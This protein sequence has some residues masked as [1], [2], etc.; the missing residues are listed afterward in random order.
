MLAQTPCYAH[1]PFLFMGNLFSSFSWCHGNISTFLPEQRSD[2]L[3]LRYLIIAVGTKVN[4]I[5]DILIL[6]WQ[7]HETPGFCACCSFTTPGWTV[8][9]SLHCCW[10]GSFSLIVRILHNALRYSD[11]R[12]ESSLS[13]CSTITS[14]FFSQDDSLSNLVRTIEDE[15]L[16]SEIQGQRTVASGVDGE[17]A[18]VT[19]SSRTITTTCVLSF[20]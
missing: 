18:F 20:S 7:R 6:R 14:L 1:S 19:S 16:R 8:D 9:H 15:E 5:I 2:L 4:N 10:N 12:G 3:L 17:S 13:L 11:V